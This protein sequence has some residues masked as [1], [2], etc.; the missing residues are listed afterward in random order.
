MGI[1]PIVTDTTPAGPI[2]VGQRTAMTPQAATPI[3]KVARRA[4]RW[5]LAAT[6]GYALLPLIIWFGV[7]DMSP[8]VFVALWYVVSAGCQ[9][10]IR[11]LQVRFGE[12]RDQQGCGQPNGRGETEPQTGSSDISGE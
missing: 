11:Q 9:A 6:L 2:N 1:T 8:F 5:M 3:P 7:R 4:V 12:R 10:L